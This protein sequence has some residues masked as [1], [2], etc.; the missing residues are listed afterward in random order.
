MIYGLAISLVCNVL[1]LVWILRLR[2]PGK[3]AKP[4][5]TMDATQLLSDLMRGGSV[6]V[7]EVINPSDIFLY[8]PKDQK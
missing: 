2:K 1:C 3:A 7:A 6:V 5:L 4:E 8:S